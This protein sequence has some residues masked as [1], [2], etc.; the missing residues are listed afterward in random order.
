MKRLALMILTIGYAGVSAMSQDKV[1]GFAARF[2]RNTY[3]ITMPYRLFTPPEYDKSKRYP[4]VLWLHGAGGIGSDNL[5]QIVNDQ[6]AG[7]HLWTRPDNVKRHPSFV[8]VP[9]SSSRWPDAHLSTALEI[10][11]AVKADFPI[12]SNRIYIIGQSIGGE[13]AWTLVTDHRRV[14]AA[15]VFVCS[16]GASKSRANTVVDLPVW[17]FQGSEDAPGVGR[18]REMIQAIRKAGGNPRYTEYKGAGHEIWNRVFKESGLVD[19]L[20]AQ[21]T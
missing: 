21:H 14:F 19:W 17:A 15:A 18:T 3:G 9:Q 7:T 20:F 12:D 2:Y 10:L 13:A 8:L 1:D 16:I 6:V 5:E 11:E 4:L